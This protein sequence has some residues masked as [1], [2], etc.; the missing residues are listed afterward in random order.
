MAPLKNLSFSKTNLIKK[1]KTVLLL[2]IQTKILSSLTVAINKYL[3]R[4]Q[5]LNLLQLK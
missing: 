2:L 1:K 3:L 5:E 4:F